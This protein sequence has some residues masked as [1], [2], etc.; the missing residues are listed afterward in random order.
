MIHQP[1]ISI[2]MNCY[3]GEK[4]LEQAISSIINQTYTNWELVFWDN[5]SE[6]RS[7]EIVSKFNDI[8]II[9]TPNL[10]YLTMIYHLAHVIIT[11]H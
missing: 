1:L 5:L 2:V 10:L 11:M 7:S 6:D 3:N 4:Y 9:S 8:R